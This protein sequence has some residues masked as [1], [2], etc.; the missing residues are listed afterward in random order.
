LRTVVITGPESTG[1]TLISEYLAIQLGCPWIPE[2]AREYIG[3]L[4]RPYIYDDL[5]HIAD[6]Q[7]LQKKNIEN[8]GA[9]MVILDTWLIITKVWF[10]EVFQQCPAYLDEMISS[11]KI[12][13]YIICKPDIPWVPDALR[14]NGGEKR[15]YLISKYIEEIRKTGH[16]YILIGGVGESRYQSALQAVKTHFNIEQ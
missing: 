2:F 8:T 9:G 10:M 7:I 16:D 14:E 3:N 11:Q 12:D 13:L 4:D 5:I 15:N 6:T 1:K